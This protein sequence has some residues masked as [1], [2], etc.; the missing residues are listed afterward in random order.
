MLKYL[1]NNYVLSLL[2]SIIVVIFVYVD[3]KRSN[4][5]KLHLASYGKLLATVFVLV[6]LALFYKTRNYSLPF[7]MPENV[8]VIKA[9]WKGGDPTSLTSGSSGVSSGVSSGGGLVIKELNLNDVNISEPQ[10]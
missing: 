4:K 7:N 3:R 5:E 10:F 2:V 6:L 1:E 8:N 9:P